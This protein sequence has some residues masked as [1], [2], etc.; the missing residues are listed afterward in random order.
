M[1]EEAGICFDYHYISDIWQILEEK[2]T[3]LNDCLVR[4]LEWSFKASSAG[5]GRWILSPDLWK[6]TPCLSLVSTYSS[7]GCNNMIN[8]V[9]LFT[10]KLSSGFFSEASHYSSLII[11][12]FWILCH[13]RYSDP[14]FTNKSSPTSFY[15]LGFSN[16]YVFILLVVDEMRVLKKHAQWS[17]IGYHALSVGSLG[18]L[19]KYGFSHQIGYPL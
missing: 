4:Y 5:S 15:R 17:Q 8:N 2:S 7:I 16:Y 12:N 6:K 11:G 19:E 13:L 3:N 18:L 9:F 1:G 10:L 14:Y